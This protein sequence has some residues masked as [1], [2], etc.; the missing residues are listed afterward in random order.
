MNASTMSDGAVRYRVD[1]TTG[2]RGV[3]LPAHCR[4]GHHLAV[5][6]YHASD[7]GGQLEVCCRACMA[8]GR[9][10][11]AWHLDT[12]PPAAASAELDDAPYTHLVSRIANHTRHSVRGQRN[13]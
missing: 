7:T 4:H 11:D 8:D 9:G 10:E 2:Q 12:Q 3:C 6:G 5:V 13:E 1:P